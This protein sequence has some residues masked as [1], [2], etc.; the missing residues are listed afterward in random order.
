MTGVDLTS[1]PVLDPTP[2]AR[3]GEHQ[4][5]RITCL[6]AALTLV[7]GRSVPIQVVERLARW[8]YDGKEGAA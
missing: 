5:Q 4:A 8:L 6:W 7:Q 2:H 1:V 3:L